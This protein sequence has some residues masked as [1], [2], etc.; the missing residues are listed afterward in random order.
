MC[1]HFYPPL[2]SLS[3]SSILAQTEDG[4]TSS[5][6][7]AASLGY[8]PPYTIHMN[9]GYP[10]HRPPY[11]STPGVETVKIAP[12]TYTR[13][14]ERAEAKKESGSGWGSW[15]AVAAAGMGVWVYHGGSTVLQGLVGNVSA[16]IGWK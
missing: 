13:K 10:T 14:A 4:V 8:A 11:P 9:G 15:I 3:P 16:R 5:L 1:I 2:H 12:P 7:A 6:L